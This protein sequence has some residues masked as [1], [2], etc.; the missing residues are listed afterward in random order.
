MERI[1]GCWEQRDL[2]KG[3]AVRP[4]L[5]ASNMGFPGPWEQELART[6]LHQG[7]GGEAGKAWATLLIR[8]PRVLVA[9][10]NSCPHLRD[11]RIRKAQS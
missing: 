6:S 7:V 3:G 10:G 5:G 8:A 11:Y 9:T 4:I 2:D 1:V